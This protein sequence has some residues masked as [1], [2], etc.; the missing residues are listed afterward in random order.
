MKWIIIA[1]ILMLISIL[2]GAFMPIATLL[3]HRQTINDND[4]GKHVSELLIGVWRQTLV[5]FACA[6]LAIIEII[7]AVIRGRGMLFFDGWCLNIVV[8]IVYC[9]WCYSGFWALE[10][11]PLIH[12]IIFTNLHAFFLVCWRLVRGETLHCLEIIGMVI[13][14]IG[15]S[16]LMIESYVTTVHNIDMKLLA[17]GATIGVC[18]SLAATV[19]IRLLDALRKTA[20]YPVFSTVVFNNILTVFVGFVLVTFVHHSTATRDIVNGWFGWMSLQWWPYAV[21]FALGTGV[22]AAGSF[23]W[24]A[25]HLSELV[26]SMLY[27]SEPP[28]TI[29]IGS[30]LGLSTNLTIWTLVSSCVVLVG[31]LVT[32]I[33]S[34]KTHQERALN[35]VNVVVNPILREHSFASSSSPV[36]LHKS[37]K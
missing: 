22:F 2:I 19:Y 9:I 23:V 3:M 32:A 4:N 28:I 17:I 6:P 20:E 33:G 25:Q 29:V 26:V 37:E 12:V 10:Y 5:L 35:K 34:W 16:L 36:I 30:M 18:G 21:Y 1:A 27:I 15:V 8:S 31:L 24:S 14:L 13:G 11:V 7:H